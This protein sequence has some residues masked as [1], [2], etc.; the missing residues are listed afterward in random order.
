[1]AASAQVITALGR[2]KPVRDASTPHAPP[3]LLPIKIVTAIKLIPGVGMH[4]L[5]KWV[6]SSAVKY[7]CFSIN[8]RWIKNVV[9]AP[10]PNDCRP[11]P[12]HRRKSCQLPGL[13][14][15]GFIPELL[16][17]GKV[18]QFNRIDGSIVS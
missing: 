11:M 15:D 17:I 14:I 8:V 3:S 7:L 2:S 12:V 10:P 1:M 4:R 18:Q 13:E 16:T 6:N 9:D 5:Q